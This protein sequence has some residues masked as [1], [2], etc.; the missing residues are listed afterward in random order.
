MATP[1]LILLSV[2]A[3]ASLAAAAPAMADSKTK[4]VRHADL[5]LSSAAGRDRLAL[6]IKQA[7]KQVCGTPRGFT[8]EERQD[9][10]ACEKQ[11]HL[12]A[13]PESARI[14]AAYMDKRRLAFE[15][16]ARVGT[17]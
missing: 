6:R 13:A 1:K 4:E 5:D 15:D 10:K 2:T 8:I 3:M 9:Q 7:V 12:R 16:T 14:I 11:A 17:N